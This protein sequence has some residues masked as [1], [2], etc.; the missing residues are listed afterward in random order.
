MVVRSTGVDSAMGADGYDAMAKWS[1]KLDGAFGLLAKPAAKISNAL[2]GGKV[3]N[4]D[5]GFTIANTTVGSAMAGNVNAS[6]YIDT[7]KDGG[8]FGSDKYRTNMESLGTEANT[9]FG[10]IIGSFADV[11]KDAN[12]EL[13]INSDL[14]ASELA[15][16]NIDIGKISFKDMSG[17][18]IEKELQAIFSKMGDDMAKWAFAGLEPFQ[19]VGEGM[20]ETVARV[21]NNLVQ[22]KDVFAVLNKSFYLTGVAAVTVSESMIDLAGGIEALTENTKFYVDNFLTEAERLA[23]ITQSVNNELMKLGISEVKT[24]EL[25][26]QKIQSLDL[27]NAADRELYV[28]MMEL[29]PAFKEAAD[30]AQ[31]LVDG[32]VDLTKAQEKALDAVNKARSALQDAYDKE[33][34]ALQ[35]VIDKTKTFIQTLASYRDSLKLGSDSPLTNM[36]KYSESGSQLEST[37]AKAMGGDQAAKD[38]FTSAA[39]AFLSASKL[40]NASGAAYLSDFAKVQSMIDKLSASATNEMDVAQASLDALNRQ[41]AGLLEVN[42]SVLTVAQAIVNLQT[43]L[44]AGSSAGL[45]NNQM[46][47]VE[48]PHT[49]IGY[50]EREGEKYYPT[51][52]AAIKENTEAVNAQRAEQKAQVGAQ[53]AADLDGT[54]RI[55]D[56][57]SG[58]PASTAP[59]I[60]LV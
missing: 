56:S 39:S 22:V 41:V 43:A 9:Q 47:V 7:K 55:V 27:M 50:H 23:P 2:F 16:F 5:T 25:F 35:G 15:A 45:T 51:M 32:T 59:S 60:K 36:Q 6:K 3:S 13:G 40:V 24:I 31:D 58:K 17:E 28:N 30:Y 26:K 8:L 53:I 42:K 11:L 29:A 54:E 19:R 57:L 12:K 14:F 34:S 44:T 38:K 18:E 20:L 49:I 10:K 21:T 33:S 37:L 1:G 48:A 52:I 46:G 4:L